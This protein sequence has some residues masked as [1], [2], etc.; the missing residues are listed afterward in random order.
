[1][2]PFEAIVD[3]IVEV[4]AAAAV[5]TPVIL[6]MTAVTV[7]VVGTIILNHG[8]PVQALLGHRR[9]RCGPRPRR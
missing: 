5:K 7:I 3:A 9:R 1:M 6:S 2:A 8:R 4:M